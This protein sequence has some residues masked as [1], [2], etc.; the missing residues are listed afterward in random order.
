MRNPNGVDAMKIKTSVKNLL[1]KIASGEQWYAYNETISE[2][3][4][5]GFIV[6]DETQI[7]LPSGQWHYI[8]WKLTETGKMIL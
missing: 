5:A 7:Q 2:A 3:V 4:K 8:G 6:Y 1:K